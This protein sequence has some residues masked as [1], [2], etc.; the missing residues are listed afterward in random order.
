MKDKITYLVIIL[1]MIP[2]IMTAQA[3]DGYMEDIK[4]IPNED[5]VHLDTIKM[6][7]TFGPLFYGPMTGA[8]GNI[9][10]GEL[11]LLRK[12]WDVYSDTNK[13][14]I[15]YVPDFGAGYFLGLA[16]DWQ[17][18]NALFGGSL[19]VFLFDT[20]KSTAYSEK[21]MDEI[22]TEYDNTTGF[23]YLTIS[24]AVRYNFLSNFH[25]FAGLDIGVSLG[26]ESYLVRKHTLG[27]EI[28]HDYKW[29]FE[30]VKTRF[31]GHLGIAYEMVLVDISQRMRVK[32]SP[33][34]SVH[35]GTGM[36]S[37]EKS[38]WNT[39][40]GRIGISFKLGPD[41][42]EYDTLMYVPQADSIPFILAT[43]DR[44]RD[45]TFPELT[46]VAKSITSGLAGV[47]GGLIE[48]DTKFESAVMIEMSAKP[49]IV[50]AIRE[51]IDIVLAGTTKPKEKLGEKIVIKEVKI[52]ELETYQFAT[53][54]STEL[55]IELKKRLDQFSDYLRRN[56]GTTIA[57]IG[58][59]DDQGNFQQNDQRAKDRAEKVKQYL[60]KKGIPEHRLLATGKGSIDP[61]A[62]NKTESGR[63]QNRRVEIKIVPGAPR[64]R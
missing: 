54:E 14:Y 46:M 25:L 48:T 23:T 34:I 13:H 2:I 1:L 32:L 52:N 16:A 24:P 35:A 9:D 33:F 56:T 51:K 19:R 12:P 18:P 37:D 28:S 39:I 7:R 55:S 15:S 40:T 47:S 29:E 20:W 43:L 59:S 30:D 22:E 57:I 64:K 38:S 10:I 4:L 3:S 5:G 58:H 26:Y 27:A 21:Y 60:M 17:P 8:N 45:I 62:S 11:Q 6:K 41:K 49:D 42:I 61:I 44:K 53:S 63:R 50:R 36:I 31:G